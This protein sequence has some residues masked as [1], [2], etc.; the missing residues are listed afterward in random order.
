MLSLSL[1]L[2][3]CIVLCLYDRGTWS[4]EGQVR[5]PR[6]FRP[7][8]EERVR[9][10]FQSNNTWPPQW[11]PETPAFKEAMR[12]REEE[13]LMI[14][15]ANERWENFMQFTQSRLVPRYTPV[16]FKLLKTPEHMQRRMK[17]A[18]DKA[19]ENW[20]SIREEPQIDAVYTPL[21]SKMV[22]LNG[23]DWEMINELKEMHEQWSGLKLKPTSAYGVRLYQNGSSL[24]MHYDKV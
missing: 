9:M 17:A 3:L 4:V 24:V 6:N 1:F 18:V 21:P 19:L 15:G 16:G 13:L 20:E 23:F 12:K 11:Q 8:E 5:G 2:A 14:P 22:S 7:S 10:W